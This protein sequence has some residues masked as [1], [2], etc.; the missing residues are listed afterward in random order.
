ELVEVAL[1]AAA[2]L[3]LHDQREAAL[4]ELLEP[5]VPRDRLQRLR[6]GEAREIEPQHADIAAIAGAADARRRAAA[7]LGPLPDLVVVGQRMRRAAGVA[8]GA[9][10][11]AGAIR[12]ARGCGAS[13]RTGCRSRGTRPARRTRLRTSAGRRRRRPPPRLA[14]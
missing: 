12:S 2:G 9:A 4:V 1:L 3:V 13:R 8:L 5:V 7:L 11:I 10:R 14:A 6:A